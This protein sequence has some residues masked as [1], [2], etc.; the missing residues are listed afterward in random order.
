M[1]PAFVTQQDPSVELH[2]FA[3]IVPIIPGFNSQYLLEAGARIV[4]ILYDDTDVL[5]AKYGHGW[6]AQMVS[7]G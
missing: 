6:S 4:Q 7:F 1:K 2:A 5:D 3:L